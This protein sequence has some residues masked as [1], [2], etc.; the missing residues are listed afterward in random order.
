MYGTQGTNRKEKITTTKA[1]KS[2][3]EA[4]HYRRQK[5]DRYKLDLEPGIM[6]HYITVT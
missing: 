5:T 1:F 6:Y 2:V 3:A 4:T